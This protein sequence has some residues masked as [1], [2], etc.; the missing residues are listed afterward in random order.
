MQQR[1]ASIRRRRVGC[2]GQGK[3]R[4]RL[5]AYRL[6]ASMPAK[7]VSIPCKS[8]VHNTTNFWEI[9]TVLSRNHE[10]YEPTDPRMPEGICRPVP[11]PCSGSPSWNWQTDKT[12]SSRSSAAQ[13]LYAGTMASMVRIDKFCSVFLFK[14]P[15]P[16][17]RILRVE[18]SH[19]ITVSQ[20]ITVLT[21]ASD[22]LAQKR[23]QDRAAI[24]ISSLL[25]P[26]SS[27]TKPIG[28]L[29]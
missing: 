20:F 7:L 15:R 3:R 18:R 12:R 10:G 27:A 2:Q 28:C 29:Q 19:S 21:N 11:T 8:N 24:E 14:F 23:S 13:S 16:I 9:C 22:Y 1:G 26:S 5:F 25:L 6:L 17:W 4:R